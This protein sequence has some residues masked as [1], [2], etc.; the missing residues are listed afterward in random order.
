MYLYK[1]I[2]RKKHLEYF[3]SKQDFKKVVEKVCQ[4]ESLGRHCTK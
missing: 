3:E 4:I 2:Y 1:I